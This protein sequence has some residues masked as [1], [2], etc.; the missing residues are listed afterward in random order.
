MAAAQWRTT[1]RME[2]S[3]WRL[4]LLSPW[5][6]P[7]W[8]NVCKETV[9]LARNDGKSRFTALVLRTWT[10]GWARSWMGLSKQEADADV[11][12]TCILSFDQKFRLNTGEKTCEKSCFDEVK[13][14][15]M[16]NFCSTW[17]LV[18]LY[19]IKLLLQLDTW[20]K[21]LWP[22]D[23]LEASLSQLWHQRA[24]YPVHPQVIPF[25]YVFINFTE[26]LKN[27]NCINDVCNNCD[28][29]ANADLWSVMVIRSDV[30]ES[31]IK[32][33]LLDTVAHQWPAA[34]GAFVRESLWTSEQ[35]TSKVHDTGRYLPLIFHDGVW[36]Q[37]VSTYRDIFRPHQ[38]A[39]LD[40]TSVA[41]KLAVDTRSRNAA[42]LTAMQDHTEYFPHAQTSLFSLRSTNSHC[43]VHPS[44]NT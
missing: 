16:L 5:Q 28:K 43:S 26:M 8:W 17:M 4:R 14:T 24:W 32:A 42:P 30:T 37:R 18:S 22:G 36:M 40:Q 10:E 31:I 44:E 33:G 35:S 2:L 29:R 23:Q 12:K 3:L 19:Q 6:P 7:L 27:L 20:N 39:V 25:I 13:I 38:I 41:L 15:W 1:P 34:Q 11:P 21:I 9:T